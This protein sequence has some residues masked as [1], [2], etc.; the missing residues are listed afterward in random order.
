MTE[1]L[2]RQARNDVHIDR[3]AYCCLL[4][5]EM[6][7]RGEAGARACVEEGIAFMERSGE[8]HFESELRRL[9]AEMRADSGDETGGS[10]A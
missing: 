10:S 7:K 1:S 2:A 9:R 5:Q 3:S 8:R 6:L 4:A